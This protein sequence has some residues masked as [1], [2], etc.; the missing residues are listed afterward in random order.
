MNI[1]KYLKLVLLI[2]GL[3]IQFL[4]A[5]TYYVDATNGNDSN[6]GTTITS[7]WKSISKLNKT[8][9]K[10]GDQIFI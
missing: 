10:P 7:A 8:T 3:S 5:T 1:L 9:F 4:Y 2:S 6:N